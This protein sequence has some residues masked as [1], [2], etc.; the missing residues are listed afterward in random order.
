MVTGGAAFTGIALLAGA[1]AFLAAA[2]AFTGAAAFLAGATFAGAEAFVVAAA[3]FLAGGISIS[4]EIVRGGNLIAHLG[5][6][7]HRRYVIS[8]SRRHF[9]RT[10][11]V[12]Q[13]IGLN[14]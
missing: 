1:A 5:F 9:F 13:A 6:G 14:R 8:T 2:G 12:L 11:E 4:F 7:Q 3:D 10:V